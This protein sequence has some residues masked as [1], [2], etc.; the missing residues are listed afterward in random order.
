M[1]IDWKKVKQKAVDI[2]IDS[3]KSFVIHTEKTLQRIEKEAVF[4]AKQNGEV[5]SD[6]A[7]EKLDDMYDKIDNV[8]YAI[9]DAE[10]KYHSKH[11][12]TD[13]EDFYEEY[14]YYDE[15]YEPVEKKDEGKCSI[16]L[17]EEELE[18]K[19][20]QQINSSSKIFELK[21]DDIVKLES[22]WYSLGKLRNIECNLIS[23]DVAGLLRLTVAG[24]IVY[25]VRVIEIKS[26]GFN[27]KVVD[28]KN[29]SNISNRKL[30]EMIY[31]NLNDIDVEILSV[32]KKSEDVDLVRALEKDMIKYYKPKWN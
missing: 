16:K 11:K 28:L 8:Y 29:Y 32:G 24:E 7:Y 21:Q 18:I 2:A 5:L 4:K 3:G 12:N 22:R 10:E 26:G 31:Q 19:A 14:E 20:E 27:K 9:D 23:T 6:E 30:R 15:Q 17:T 25:I 1:N 13:E